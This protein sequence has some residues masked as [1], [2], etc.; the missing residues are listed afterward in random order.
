MQTS[1]L[2]NTH[3]EPMPDAT[4][5]ARWCMRIL[6]NPRQNTGR[7]HRDTIR[8]YVWA[9]AQLPFCTTA[10]FWTPVFVKRLPPFSFPHRVGERED[11]PSAR[12]LSHSQSTT[13][14]LYYSGAAREVGGAASGSRSSPRGRGKEE[15]RRRRRRGGGGRA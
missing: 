2:L 6:H 1:R 15:S 14:L 11:E 5:H 13:G 3:L 4:V 8:V 9:R 10:S 7:G 12:H